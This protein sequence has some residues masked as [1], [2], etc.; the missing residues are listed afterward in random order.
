MLPAWAT[1]NN[2]ECR[3]EELAGNA[4]TPEEPDWRHSDTVCF[5]ECALQ[6][7]DCVMY[8]TGI[9]VELGGVEYVLTECACGA[10]D[11]KGFLHILQEDTWDLLTGAG[12]TQCRTFGMVGLATGTNDGALCINY[13]C[14]VDCDLL[15]V[16]NQPPSPLSMEIE[17]G[18]W[19]EVVRLTCQCPQ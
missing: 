4:G 18:V 7:G 13:D 5:G 14:P 16:P 17:P 1:G 6:E 8:E 12:P 11:S 10:A 19:V 3:I 2:G 9:T 15:P